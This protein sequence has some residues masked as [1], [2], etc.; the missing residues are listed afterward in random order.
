MKKDFIRR[1]T[2]SVDL[3]C[4]PVISTN[5]YGNSKIYSKTGLFFTILALAILSTYA[6]VRL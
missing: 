1:V 2:D 6:I 5:I 3:F 4:E